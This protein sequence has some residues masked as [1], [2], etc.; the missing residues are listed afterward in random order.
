[1]NKYSDEPSA[2]VTNSAA[3]TDKN[4]AN[5]ESQT[6]V[7]QYILNYFDEII[8][9][10]SNLNLFTDDVELLSKLVRKI[11]YNRRQTI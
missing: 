9:T 11:T 4:D 3:S 5:G 7:K 2:E 6:L 10:L 8:K 1:M